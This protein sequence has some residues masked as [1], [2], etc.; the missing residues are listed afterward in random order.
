MMR[1]GF[2][3]DEISDDVREALATGLSWG[4]KDYELRVIE[5]KRIPD[6]SEQNIQFLLAQQAQHGLRYTALSP[7]IF[8]APIEN[9][10][11]IRHELEEVLP[12]T[13]QLARRL[14]SN[15]VIVF[16]FKREAHEPAEN[17]ERVKEIFAKA[18]QRAAEFDITLAVENEPGFWCDTGSNTAKILLEVNHPNLRANWDPANAYGTD[19]LPYP[20]GYRH[21][22]PFIVNLHIKDTPDSTLKTCVPVGEGQVDWGGQLEAVVKDGILDHVTIET[23]C[24]PL[25]ENS[26]LNLQRVRE[27]LSRSMAAQ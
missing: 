26:A 8:K 9:V 16:G 23:H 27:I 6:I 7:G 13:L 17:R 10:S 21:L 1:I 5:G 12:Q 11:T 15:L 20:D 18:A 22:R 2:V 25:K 4:I 19:E 3:T 24:L 14:H